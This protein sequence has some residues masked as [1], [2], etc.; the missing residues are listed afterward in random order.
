MNEKLLNMSSSPHIRHRLTT[1]AVMT[2]VVLALLPAA[3]FGIYRYGI[4]AFL[5]LLISVASAV[6]TEFLY[7]KQLRKPM[8]VKDGSAVVTGLLLGLSLSPA[9]PLYLPCLGS[10]FAILFVKCFFGGLGKNFMNPALTGRCF[11]LISFGSAMTNFSVDGMSS[12]TPLAALRAGEAV[13]LSQTALGYTAGVIG[14]SAVALLIGGIFLLITGG[15]T[16]EIPAA[17]VAAFAVFMGLFG[18]HGFDPNY[19]LI[20]ICG[21]GVLMGAFF[22]ATDPV[23]SPVT[24]RGQLLYGAITGILAGLFRVYGSSADSV[25]YAII[26]ANMVVPFIDQDF[27]PETA[28]L[29]RRIRKATVSKGCCQPDDHHPVCRTCTQQCL[30]PDQG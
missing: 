4:H 29:S 1:G 15:I 23:T 30:S 3:V 9:V 26:I 13:S 20:H 21:G 16:I 22:M 6:A 10:V 18:G 12:A 8:T 19:L 5:I 7:D 17:F 28:R 2:D 11:L 27:C 25:S 14:G 24:S